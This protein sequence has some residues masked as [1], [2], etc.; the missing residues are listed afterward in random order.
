MATCGTLTV[1][2]DGGG[3]NGGGAPGNGNGDGTP[4]DGVPDD[5]LRSPTFRTAFGAGAGG[6]LG[7]GIAALRDRE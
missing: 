6:L 2:G 3:G 7:L 1:S 5:L 4:G